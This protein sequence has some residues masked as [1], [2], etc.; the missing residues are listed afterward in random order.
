MNESIPFVGGVNL[1]WYA[2]TVQEIARTDFAKVPLLDE[3]L[4]RSAQVKNKR[5]H[6]LTAN[7]LRDWSATLLTQ[8]Y[9]SKNSKKEWSRRSIAIAKRTTG[10]SL[11]FHAQPVSTT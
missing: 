3:M 2:V 8:P 6:L 9:I 11:A 10:T 7:D 4:G 1:V 5:M